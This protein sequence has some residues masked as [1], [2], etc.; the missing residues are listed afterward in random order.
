MASAVKTSVT[1]LPESRVRVQAEVPSD[2]VERQLARAAS[3]LGRQLR[4]PGFR[5]GK[6]PPPVIIRRVGRDAVLDEAVRDSLGRWYVQAVD[7]AGIVPVGD[8]KLDLGELPGEGEPLTF[9]IEIGVRPSA[10][11]GEYKGLEVGRREPEVADEAVESEVQALRERLAKLES[12]ERPAEQ[13]DFVVMDYKGSISDP[14]GSGTSEASGEPF[15]GGEGR[16]QLLELGSGRLVEGFEDQLVGAK[17]GEERTVKV[18]F[19]EDY[20]AEE[21]A[22]KDVSFAV[23]V[24]DVKRK[25]LPEL[26]DD[27]AVDAAGFDSLD[28]LRADVRSKLEE[29][30][31]ER[32][33]SDYRQAVLDAAVAGADVEVPNDL[34]H[35]R[36]HELLHNLLHSLE[37]R[38]I[39]KEAYLQISGKDEEELAREA[40][41][42]AEQAL[43]REAVLAAVVENEG[44]EPS[45]EEVLAALKESGQGEEQPAEK[46]LE[47]LRKAGR[48][49]ALRDDLAA[50]QAVDLL[51]HAA[52]P[53]SVEQAKA[54]DKL[55]TP[56]RDRD[57]GAAAGQLWTPG[58]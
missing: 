55:W 30:D 41:P 48:L 40:E 50:R 46:L 36:A 38:G 32:I 7:D 57:E 23:T 5:K 49:E 1:E 31:R 6:V 33:E 52:T 56:E 28:E 12:V 4:I 51:V 25:E 3:A 43:K 18:S 58:S 26:D 27:L 20:R 21:L 44:I 13:G 24:K 9:S 53:I 15:A 8:P 29:A 35:A 42:D 45:E 14:K 17:A 19:P 22:G 16:D 2:E 37:H 39:S 34:V 47:R 54:R 11:L 10:T